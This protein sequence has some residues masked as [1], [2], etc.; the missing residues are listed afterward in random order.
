MAYP[1]GK[2]P[3]GALSPIYQGEL[4]NEAAAGWNAMNVE[5]RKRGVE[6]YPTGSRSSYRTYEEQEEL[7]QDYLNG[8]GNLAAVPGTSNHGTGIAVDCAT[9][10]MRDMIDLI[11]KSYGWSKSWSDAP[12]EWW[13]ICYQGGHYSGPDPGPRGEGVVTTPPTVTVAPV[14]T[15]TVLKQN[16]CLE[17]FTEDASGEVFHRWQNAPNSGWSGWHSM[18]KP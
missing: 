6:L 2:Y 7:Y 3:P 4:I 1:N 11:G 18:G 14:T 16:G 9:Y 5:A 13:H 10:D 8:T 12:S 15:V 17:L